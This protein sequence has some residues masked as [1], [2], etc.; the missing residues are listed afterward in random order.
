MNEFDK[1]YEI[2][3][4]HRDKFLPYDYDCIL[5]AFEYLSGFNANFSEAVDSYMKKDGER[6]CVNTCKELNQDDH[7]KFERGLK[8]IIA[9]Y[10][11]YFRGYRQPKQKQ[12]QVS[13]EINQEKLAVLPIRQVP[14]FMSNAIKGKQ[15]DQRSSYNI[16]QLGKYELVLFIYLFNQFIRDMGRHYSD[17]Y[18]PGDEIV[19]DYD[20]IIKTA[21][22]EMNHRAK[23]YLI[24]AIDVL[25]ETKINV[26]LNATEYRTIH[27]LSVKRNIETDIITGVYLHPEARIAGSEFK[28]FVSIDV[29]IYKLI[30]ETKSARTILYMTKFIDISKSNSKFNQYIDGTAKMLNEDI[31]VRVYKHRFK[32]RLKE[33]FE[34]MKRNGLI[35]NFRMVKEH[36][37]VTFTKKGLGLSEDNDTNI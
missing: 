17:T 27:I 29:D 28:K 37:S 3:L 8:I 25:S 31:S 33:C 10:A 7:E 35:E 18:K 24:A 23:E 16:D 5:F 30:R 12:G 20:H 13:K 9:I 36:V 2:V 19:L 6:K 15:T 4:S 21:G 32:E 22:L 34:I 14:R 11:K 26:V 1:V